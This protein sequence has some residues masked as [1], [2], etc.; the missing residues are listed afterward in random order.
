ML[1]LLKETWS[2][3]YAVRRRRRCHAPVVRRRRSCHA[4]VGKRNVVSCSCCQKE[5]VVMLLFLGER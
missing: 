4:P 3:A 2:L 5:K 1:L